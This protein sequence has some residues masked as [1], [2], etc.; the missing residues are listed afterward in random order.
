MPNRFFTNTIDLLPV[1]RARSADVES[2]FSSVEAGF[3][4]VQSEIDSKAG[5][6]SP[7][8]TGTPTAPTA[9]T[10]T[11]STQLATAAFVQQEIA[12]AASV[13][14]PT[15][16]GNAGRFLRSDGS[17]AAWSSLTGPINI[18]SA[19]TPAT[20]GQTYVL[21]ASLTLTLPASPTAG[22]WVTIVNQ[23]GTTTPVVARNGSNIMSLAE[24]LT[25][26][27][28]NAPVRLVFVNSARGWVFA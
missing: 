21:T 25:L 22:D 14:L 7:A 1:T 9:G 6:N 15:V 27:S 19:N 4:G 23:S 24:D 3:D 26:D 16:A 20:Q 10:G 13:N 5:L 11:N 8:F 18:I 2:N 12:A 28:S 17:L